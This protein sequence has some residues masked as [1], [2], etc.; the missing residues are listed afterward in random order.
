MALDPKEIAQLKKDLK[1]LNTLREKLGGKPVEVNFDVVGQEGVKQIAQLLDQARASVIDLEEGFGGIAQ[2]IKNIVREWKPGF[3]DPTKE[4][5]KSFTK[6]KGIAEKLSE[7]VNNITNLNRRQLSQTRDQIKAEQIRL[8]NLKDELSQ[9]KNLS[10]EEKT[11]LDNLNSQYSVTEDLLNQTEKRLQTEEKIQKT[12]GLTGQL[13]KGI[14]GTLKKIGVDSQDLENIESSM[15]EAAKSGSKLKA[16][17]AGLKGV[18]GALKNAFTDPAVQ[19]T[20]LVKAFKTLYDIGLSYSKLTAQIAKNQAIST[21]EAQKTQDRL[22]G[23]ALAS[24]DTLMTTTNLVEATNSL[25]DAYGTSADFSAKTLED[26]LKLTKNL[27]LSNEE[28]A[29]YA[30]LSTLTGKTQEEIVNSI[31][32]QRKGVI[33]NRKVLSEVAK[34]NGQL[35]AQYKG[36][37]DLISKAV[38]QTQKLGMSLQQA[39]AAS[40]QLLNFEESISAEL[41]AELLTGRDINLEKARYLALQGDSAGAAEELRKQVGSLA[42]FQ[43]LNVIQQEALAK[44]AGMTVDEL[45]NS[46]VKSEQ[47]KNL[48]QAQV[49][50]YQQQIKELKDKGQTE[51]ANALEQQMMAGKSLELANVQADAQERLTRAGEKFKDTLSSIIAGPVGKSLEFLVGGFEKLASSSIGQIAITGAVVTGLAAA[52]MTFGKIFGKV[53]KNGAVPVTVEGGGPGGGIGGGMGTGGSSSGGGGTFGKGTLGRMTSKGGRDVLRRA[54]KGS[55][56]KG[57]GK[58]ALSAGKGVLKGGLRGIPMAGALLG[59]GLE[60][61]EGGFNMET[62]GR[63]ALSGLGSF[64]GGAL[65]SLLLPGVGTF[66]GAVAGGMAG[67]ALGDLIFGA[68][69]EP[70]AEDFIMKD[71][72]MT[73]FRKDDVVVGGTNLG[74]SNSPEVVALLKELIATVKAGGDVYLD[75]T[76]VGTAMAMSTYKTQ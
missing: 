68:K 65:G 53:A 20:L 19:I 4:A 28:A 63:A 48:D 25:N 46:L 18:F 44:A 74:G 45:T 47:L 3:A 54:G 76:K 38:I 32:K 70:P 14:S 72:K 75:G 49:K 24:R 50:L 22:R 66:G 36:S 15:Y 59:A 2:S 12:L 37:P 34:V 51:K 43:R 30:K 40:R 39:Q 9:R 69:E 8:S 26:N 16:V 29:E 62:A 31:G 58:G 21:S 17:G 11:I 6:L 10:E 55:L 35:F 1:E 23:I 73:R 5:T 60:F 61:A 56:V 27:G 71:G 52:I 42:D 13:F 67:D 7:D 64:G 57:I 41:E 33:S